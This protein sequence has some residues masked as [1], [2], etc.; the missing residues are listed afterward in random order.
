MNA[1]D[2]VR[3]AYNISSEMPA[4]ISLKQLLCQAIMLC[5]LGES[6]GWMVREELYARTN[7]EWEKLMFVPPRNPSSFGGAT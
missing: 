2:V 7:S 4:D 6:E 5:V 3:V 1:K